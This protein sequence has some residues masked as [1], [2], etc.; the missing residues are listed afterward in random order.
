MQ[1][2]AGQQT[3]KARTEWTVRTEQQQH[4]LSGDGN[5]YDT[6]ELTKN[7]DMCFARINLWNENY[8]NLKRKQVFAKTK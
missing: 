6:A 5:T 4:F 1:K 3:C 7:R 8:I 2:C